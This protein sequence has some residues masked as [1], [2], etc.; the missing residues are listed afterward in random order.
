MN[1][2]QKKEIKE[3]KILSFIGRKIK[4][5]LKEIFDINFTHGTVFSKYFEEHNICVSE[6]FILIHFDK[7]WE[8]GFDKYSILFDYLFFKFKIKKDKINISSKKCTT[9]E[10]FGFE[11]PKDR[12]RTDGLGFIIDID[13]KKIYKILKND[14]N[15]R[16]KYE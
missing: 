4:K 9:C 11:I 13:Y 8:F 15:K 3:K 1:K 10:N 2:I 5:D 14:N 12:V 6:T 7:Y 16:V